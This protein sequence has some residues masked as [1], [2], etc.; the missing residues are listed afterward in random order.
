MIEQV[1]FTSDTHFGHK[2]VAEK[3]RGYT[4]AGEM[5]EEIIERWNKA[6]SP[7]DRVYHLGDVSLR[8]PAETAKILSR[9]NGRIYLIRGNHENSAE[10]TKCRDRFEW[11]K[12]YHYLKLGGHK[13]ALLHYPMLSWRSSHH[14]SYHLHGH[15]HGH[16]LTNDNFKR[17]DVGVDCWNLRPVPWPTVNTVLSPREP[18]HHHTDLNQLT[19]EG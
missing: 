3:Y 7:G 19:P 1:W 16:L 11:I 17:L 12:D 6:I 13:I 2:M 8:K 4:D 9:L 14:G 10:S 5:D 15:C 18:H